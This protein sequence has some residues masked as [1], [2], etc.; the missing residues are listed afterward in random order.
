MKLRIKLN[1]GAVAPIFSTAGSAGLDLSSDS[2]GYA[3]QPG[4]TTMVDTGVAVAIPTGYVG[5]VT[6]RS[7]LHKLG[8]SLQNK[9]GVIDSDYRGSIKLALTTTK[10]LGVEIAPNTRMAQLLI[11]PF[12]KV[13]MEV[14]D[15]LPSTA[16]GLGGFGS[17]G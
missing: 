3:V 1:Q 17:T 6:E 14:V 2:R 16:R 9:V 10:E 7:S 13:Y 4:Q 5:I 12:K 15:E 8:V 11:V